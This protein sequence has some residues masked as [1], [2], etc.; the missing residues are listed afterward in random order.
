M[1]DYTLTTTNIIAQMNYHNDKSDFYRLPST[2][3]AKLT[4]RDLT[5]KLIFEKNWQT[6]TNK[7]KLSSHLSGNKSSNFRARFPI[8]TAAAELSHFRESFPAGEKLA[9]YYNY[10]DAVLTSF[11]SH[12]KLDQ[13]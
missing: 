2:A 8:Q 3:R 13:N 7:K 4:S 5:T 1:N 10:V 9:Y 6:L 12:G 11:L